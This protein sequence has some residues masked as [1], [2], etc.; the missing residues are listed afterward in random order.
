MEVFMKKMRIFFS[1]FCFAAVLCFPV[2]SFSDSL[3]EP[4]EQPKQP[5]RIQQCINCCTDKR[6][7]CYIMNPDRRLCEAEF[8]NCVAT[9]KSEGSVSSDWSE[10]WS[11]S[12]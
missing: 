4:S 2:F 12:E 3:A 10:C 5:E 6:T 11:L 1:V 7:A 8:Q 9:C